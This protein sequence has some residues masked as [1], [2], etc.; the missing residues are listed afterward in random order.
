MN[1]NINDKSPL[2]F[3]VQPQAIICPKCQY[4]RTA[5]DPGPDWQCPGCGVAYNKAA[6]ASSAVAPRVNSAPRQRSSREVVHDEL[7]TATPS[8]I[9]LSIDGRI[10]RL[11]YLA[12]SVP[13]IV[14]T[15]LLG[16]LAAII[17]PKHQGT[18]TLFLIIVGV[19]W[20]WMPLRLMALRM[21]DVNRSAKWLLG[22]LLL[23]GLAF[24]LG[25]LQTTVICTG[26]FWI[27]AL[28][29]IVLPGSDGDNDYGPSP[30]PNTTLVN[31]GA[32]L[33]LVFMAL[34]VIGEMRMKHSFN[35]ALLSPQGTTT[36][37]PGGRN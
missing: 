33:F 14:L 29:L 21:H 23:P 30:G 25:G 1:A 17:I 4:K 20:F 10:G 12:F 2:G 19:L 6:A 34:G 32:G 36:Q 18:G 31:V 5:S 8:V 15:S 11:R 7:E 3:S 37:L 24:P 13:T 22:L 27:V 9:A 28:L 26:L 16:V 35:P